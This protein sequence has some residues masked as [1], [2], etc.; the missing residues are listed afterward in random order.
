[1]KSSESKRSCW[2]PAL[3]NPKAETDNL[4]RLA[5]FCS[6]ESL[7]FRS[8]SNRH[9]SFLFFSHFRLSRFGFWQSPASI[10]R[11]FSSSFSRWHGRSSAALNST[12]IRNE[13]SSRSSC[14]RTGPRPCWPGIRWNPVNRSDLSDTCTKRVLFL[15]SLL[16]QNFSFSF[17][18]SRFGIGQ[19]FFFSFFYFF[20]SVFFSFFLLE[21]PDLNEACYRSS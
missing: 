5:I 3:P 12:A 7:E 9:E 19:S 10:F 14:S 18:F 15:F 20:F 21:S 11:K 2:T 13:T 1:M 6:T 8:V 17:Y 16:Y 4:F